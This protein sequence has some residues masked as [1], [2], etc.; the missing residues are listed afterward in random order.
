MSHYFELSVSS[1]YFCPVIVNLHDL[2][3]SAKEVNCDL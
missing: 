3:F 1:Q 2:I